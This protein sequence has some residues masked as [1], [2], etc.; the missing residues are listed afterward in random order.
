MMNQELEKANINLR[1]KVDENNSLQGSLRGLQSE[2]DN[3][4]RQHSESDLRT[5]QQYKSQI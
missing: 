3:L 1:N 4:R 5:S 2:N